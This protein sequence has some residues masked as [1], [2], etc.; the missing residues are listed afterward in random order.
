MTRRRAGPIGEEDEKW[1]GTGGAQDVGEDDVDD[2]P[3]MG[4]YRRSLILLII[5][6]R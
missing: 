1:V 2:V 3:D 4:F 6:R 5:E